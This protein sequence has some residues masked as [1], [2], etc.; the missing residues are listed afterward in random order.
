MREV[1]LGTSS[2]HLPPQSCIPL[3]DPHASLQS[4]V[5]TLFWKT[6]RMESNFIYGGEMFYRVGITAEG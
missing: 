3:L 6:K 5:L 2:R 4:P 1:T